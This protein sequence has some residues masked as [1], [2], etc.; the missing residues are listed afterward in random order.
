ML[1]Y[2]K[3]AVGESRM[4]NV[5]VLV[6][7]NTLKSGGTTYMMDPDN[8][9]VYAG[10]A[11]VCWVP[12]KDVKVTDGVSSEGNTIIH[13]LGGHGIAKLGDEYAYRGQGEIPSEAVNAIKAEQKG[14]NC[15]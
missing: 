11:S 13:E 15:T 4:D 7:M 2:A 8:K 14:K 5:A 3:K 10:G 6:L 12:Y 9:S 1:G